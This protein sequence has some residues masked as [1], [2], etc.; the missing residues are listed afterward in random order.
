MLKTSSVVPS[1]YRQKSRIAPGAHGSLG[2]EIKAQS[3]GKIMA[4]AAIPTDSNVHSLW[5]PPATATTA[6][7]A[8]S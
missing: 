7:R 2:F 3:R 5:L 8:L 4:I 1:P 6:V